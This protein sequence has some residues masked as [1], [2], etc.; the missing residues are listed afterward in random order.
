[1][2]VLKGNRKVR[3]SVMILDIDGGSVK[4]RVKCE[5]EDEILYER[6]DVLC[7][8]DTVDCRYELDMDDEPFTKMDLLALMKGKL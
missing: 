2:I 8:H 4:V 1:M 3:W 5:I 7:R 6:T